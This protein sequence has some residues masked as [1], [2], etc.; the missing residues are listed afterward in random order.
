MHVL[1]AS[2]TSAHTDNRGEE[3][4]TMV[5][6]TLKTLADFE[7][8]KKGQTIFVSNGE[9]EPPKHHTR[10]HKT[11]SLRNYKGFVHHFTFS[12]GSLVEFNNSMDLKYRKRLRVLT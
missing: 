12:G 8:L 4:V 9:K 3:N 10:K 7:Q 11:W 5:R 6:K 1:S 2:P